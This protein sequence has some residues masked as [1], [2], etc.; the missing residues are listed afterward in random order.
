[1]GKRASVGGWLIAG[2]SLAVLFGVIALKALA[3]PEGDSDFDDE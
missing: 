1:M 3:D 2:V